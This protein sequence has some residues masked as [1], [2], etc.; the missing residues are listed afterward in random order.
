M[1]R[2]LAPKL[3][4][5]VD[6][7]VT[8]ISPSNCLVTPYSTHSKGISHFQKSTTNH[9]E[10]PQITLVN[11]GYEGGWVRNDMWLFNQAVQ[12]FNSY[13]L[14]ELRQAITL[15]RIS[16]SS[17]KTWSWCLLDCATILKINIKALYVSG[18]EHTLS[19]SRYCYLIMPL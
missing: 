10:Y 17:S 9:I 8:L 14:F 15:L 6:A 5:F 1:L 3:G 13:E 11:G 16:V 7:H 19:I 12:D 18:T 4:F 2:F